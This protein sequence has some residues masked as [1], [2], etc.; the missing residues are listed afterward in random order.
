MKSRR[1]VAMHIVWSL[2]KSTQEPKPAK[3]HAYPNALEE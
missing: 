3:E 1:F 2:E